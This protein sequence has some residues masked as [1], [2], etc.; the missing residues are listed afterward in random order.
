MRRLLSL[1]FLLLPLVVTTTY[2]FVTGTDITGSFRI[3]HAGQHSMPISGWASASEVAAALMAM[4]SIEDRVIVEDYSSREDGVME[5]LVTFSDSAGNVDDMD[6]DLSDLSSS[7]PADTLSFDVT[8]E[9]EGELSDGHGFAYL[10]SDDTTCGNLHLMDDATIRDETR[11]SNG[12]FKTFAIIAEAK[13]SLGGSFDVFYDGTKSTIELSDT[14]EAIEASIQSLSPSLYEA[15]VEE[16][17]Y[18]GNMPFGKTWFLRYPATSEGNDELVISDK[19]TTGSDALVDVYPVLSISTSAEE[20]DIGGDYRIHVGDEVTLPIAMAATENDIMSELH[21]LVGVGTVISVGND[22]SP[23]PGAIG[24]DYSFAIM[25][26]TTDLDSFRVEPELNWSGTD[27]RIFASGP[28]G[29][30]PMHYVIQT[31]QDSGPHKVR[32]SAHNCQGFGLP[33]PTTTVAPDNIVPGTPRGITFGDYYRSDELYLSFQPPLHDGGTPITKYKIEW[34]TSNSFTLAQSDEISI[35]HEEQEIMLSCTSKCHGTFTLQWGGKVSDPIAVDATAIAME[36]HISSLLGGDAVRVS[37]RSQGFGYRWL[38]TF[39][40]TRGNLGELVADGHWM[41]GGNPHVWVERVV[42]G[43]ADIY[44]GSFTTEVQTV[45]VSKLP[46]FTTTATGTFRLSF[47]DEITEEIDVSASADEVKGALEAIE[48]IHTV[49]VMKEEDL[50]GQVG[51]VITFS[52][53][54]DTGGKGAGDIA[55]FEVTDA[56]LSEP[57]VTSI[58]VFENVKGT[59]PL[60]YTIDGLTEG[61]MYYVHISAQNEVGWSTPSIVMSAIPRGQPDVPLIA[62]ASI[63]PASGSTALDVTWLPPSTDGGDTISGYEVE[64]YSNPGEFEIQEIA[65]TSSTRG[66]ADIQ[67]I[68]TAADSDSISGFFSIS[69]MG[70]QTEPIAY[71]A[72]AD[73]ENSLESKLERLSTIGNVAVTRELSTRPVQNEVFVLANGST[74][75][76]RAVGSSTDMAALFEVSDIIFV[77]GERHVVSAVS[78]SS[79][80]IQAAY[81]GPSSNEA[82]VYKWAY[83]YEWQIEFESHVGEQP[84]LQVEPGENWAGE[85]PTL[86]VHHTTRG[87]HPMSGTFRLSFDGE[88]TEPLPWNAEENDVKIALEGLQGISTVDVTRY[89]N[90]Q[91]FN[92]FVTFTDGGNVPLMGMNHRMLNGPNAKARVAAI[93][94]G[95]EKQNYGQVELAGTFVQSHTLSDLIQ[96]TPY[97][98]GVRAKNIEGYGRTRLASPAPL[99]PKTSPNVPVDS[100]IVPLSN[101]EIEVTWTQPANDG[102]ATIEKYRIDWDVT[103]EF[104]NSSSPGFHTFVDGQEDRYVIHIDPLSSSIP[105]HVRMSCYNGHSWSEFVEA[106]GSPVRASLQLPGRVDFS[107]R[108]TSAIGSMLEWTAP[109]DGGSDISGYLIEVYEK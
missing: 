29:Q 4:P 27:A 52:H 1:L 66:V 49:N 9:I 94:E 54:I 61:Q 78:T 26:H 89:T 48:S 2:A 20:D 18:Q 44:P 73:G 5:W 36:A 97:Y 58:Q 42:P 88:R 8:T 85:N 69:F 82:H 64:Y 6:M 74:S 62:N 25:A 96:G 100:K 93:F 57:S 21:Q 77:G 55:L 65:V 3:Q 99:A 31:D 11:C 63:P 104:E 90:A 105:R 24:V 109:H 40:N 71:N 43:S 68:R 39:S 19:M 12:I 75:I 103:D 107:A 28:N 17:T 81:A 101:T 59:D 30:I 15:T 70:E 72:L 98:I 51:W 7:N 92:W 35:Q 106:E 83:G 86:D 16:R 80:T 32:V 41:Y 47:E 79:I 46:G 50:N 34:S 91:G 95:Q 60:I 38:V 56:T 13:S 108:V 102:G 76:G 10:Y 53:V 33:S 37:R 87:L 67:S 14:V 22:S 84:V 45:Y 23:P